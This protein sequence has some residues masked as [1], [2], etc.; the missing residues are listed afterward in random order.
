MCGT[1]RSSGRAQDLPVASGRRGSPHHPP[2]FEYTLE[3]RSGQARAGLFSLRR[4]A[5][6]RTPGLHARGHPRCRA[7]RSDAGP[8]P[9]ER[10]AEIVLSNTYHLA[11]R[12]GQALVE[13]FGGLHEFMRWDGPILTDSA[14]ASRSSQPARHPE[15]RHRRWR[16]SSR[17]RSTATQIEPHAGAARSRS[18]TQLGAD[19]IMA[20]D[21]CTPY[22]G[23]APPRP[24]Q[25]VR[26]TLSW[27]SSAA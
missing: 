20:F 7:R 15:S 4:T 1:R 21:E 18:S 3:A 11:L 17:T 8:G 12:P 14:A 10:A 27:M 13:K 23:G 24:G 2:M 25:G 22:P 5:T 16:A 19:I 9:G 6:I 26:R